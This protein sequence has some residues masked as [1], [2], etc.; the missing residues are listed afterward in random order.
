LKHLNRYLSEVRR[1]LKPKKLFLRWMEYTGFPKRSSYNTLLLHERYGQKLPEFAYLGTRKLLAASHLEN[2]VEYVEK[3]E[4]EIV[5]ETA[6]DFEKRV[7]KLR[8]KK[9]KKDG[10]GRKPQYTEVGGCKIRLSENGTRIVVEGLSKKRQAAL[11]EVIKDAL[12]Q[13]KD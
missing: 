12:S 3:H 5:K 13:E 4:E 11:L 2:C 6:E 8:A 9:T 7:R 10:R 1:I